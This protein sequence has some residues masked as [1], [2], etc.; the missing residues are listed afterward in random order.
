[1]KQHRRG[2]FHHKPSL[3]PSSS[4]PSLAV[5]RCTIIITTTSAYE[6]PPFRPEPAPRVRISNSGT[7]SPDSSPISP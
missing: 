5:R 2:L 7:D 3:P 1:M 6:V 4:S